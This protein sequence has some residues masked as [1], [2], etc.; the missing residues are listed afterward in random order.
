MKNHIYREITEQDTESTL[1]NVNTFNNKTCIS[2]ELSCPLC[3]DKLY[4]NVNTKRVRC[5]KCRMIFNQEA[6][7]RI[8]RKMAIRNDWMRLSQ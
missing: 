3:G 4:E 1:K 2:T 6:I 5:L 8:K 7:E